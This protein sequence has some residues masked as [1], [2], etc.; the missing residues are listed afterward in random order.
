VACYVITD[1]GHMLVQKKQPSL[2]SSKTHVQSFGG[3]NYPNHVARMM[4]SLR[5]ELMD[6]CGLLLSENN[7]IRSSQMIVSPEGNGATLLQV[8]LVKDEAVNNCWSAEEARRV[9]GEQEVPPEA[10]ANQNV[11]AKV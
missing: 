8:L 9:L 3:C 10:G 1:A 5:L 4:N 7:L 2:F 6:E 11:N